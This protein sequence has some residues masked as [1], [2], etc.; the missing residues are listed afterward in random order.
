MKDCSSCESYC[1]LIIFSDCLHTVDK[2]I[3]IDV[4]QGDD[5]TPLFSM[6]FEAQQQKQVFRRPD[7][8]RFSVLNKDIVTVGYY[9]YYYHCLLLSFI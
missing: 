3:N 2:Q 8:Q 6:F 5:D 4:L 9:Y 7:L 1:M